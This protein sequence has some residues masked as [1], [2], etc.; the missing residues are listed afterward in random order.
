MMSSRR[1][2]DAGVDGTTGLN[3]SGVDGTS[4]LSLS[5]SLSMDVRRRGVV[6]VGGADDCMSS[7]PSALVLFTLSLFM[8]SFMLYAGD[9][10][11]IGGK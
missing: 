8:F 11:M 10:D 2:F 6:G 9:E 4:L 1:C 7:A 3:G 5:L